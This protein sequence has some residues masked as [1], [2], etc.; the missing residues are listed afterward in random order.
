MAMDEYHPIYNPGGVPPT[1]KSQ[2]P[3]APTSAELNAQTGDRSDPNLFNFMPP[4]LLEYLDASR[5][6]VGRPT[7]LAAQQR[8]E[9]TT[10]MPTTPTVGAGASGAGN[11]PI[12]PLMNVMNYRE[13]PRAHYTPMASMESM[14]PPTFGAAGTPNPQT[15]PNMDML[16]NFWL[17]TGR[18]EL[19]EGQPGGRQWLVARGA[20]PH[21][22]RMLRYIN[23]G[24][25]LRPTFRRSSKAPPPLR[26]S[27]PQTNKTGLTRARRRRHCGTGIF[28]RGC[29]KAFPMNT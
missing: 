20:L 25:S 22:T 23:E 29:M 26:A 12:N 27:Q 18:R 24:I 10:P 2:M 5:R 6:A 13:P 21:T 17:S 8:Q 15:N 7:G 16:F 11:Q 19:I 14:T 3:K 9:R 4:A 28:L 1:I